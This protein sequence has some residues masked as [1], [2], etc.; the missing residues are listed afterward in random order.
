MIH[1]KQV[2]IGDRIELVEMHDDPDPIP[3]GT[4]GTVDWVNELPEFA[5]I[6]VRWDNGRTLML[7]VPPDSFRVVEDASHA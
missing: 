1:P 6:G 2:A 3:A 5:Q 4:Q 7:C